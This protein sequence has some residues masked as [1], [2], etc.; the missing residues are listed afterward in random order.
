MEGCQEL[1]E[2][3]TLNNLK[4]PLPMNNLDQST[5][6]RI[7]T[8]DSEISFSVNPQVYPKDVIFKA[9]Y[10]LIDKIYVFLD[11]PGKKEIIVFLKTKEKSTRK[12]LE[13]LRDEFL[14]ELMNASIRKNVARKNQKIVEYIVGG[15]IT[16]A[17]A[18]PRGEGTD[19]N[20]IKDEEILKIEKEI[21]ALKKELEEESPNG[22]QEE[23]PLKIRKPVK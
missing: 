6:T 13:R 2:D 4:G 16:A 14:N 11:S 3:R 21:A 23:D 22:T 9:C 20:N 1:S 17:L 12:Q 15:A 18:K 19:A 5:R 8:E 10:G 7:N